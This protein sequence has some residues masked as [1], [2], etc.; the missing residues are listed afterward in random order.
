MHTTVME[1]PMGRTGRGCITLL[2]TG[3][4]SCCK[5]SISSGTLTL[6][7]KSIIPPPQGFIVVV[8]ESNLGAGTPGEQGRRGSVTKLGLMTVFVCMLR[9]STPSA[10]PWLGCPRVGCPR[11]G[12]P[13]AGCPWA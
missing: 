5:R 13:W 4:C 6:V 3:F 9:L 2:E 8:M 1:E 10:C 7:F 12:C 11:A